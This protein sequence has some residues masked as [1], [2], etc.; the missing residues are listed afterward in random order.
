[1]ALTLCK[2]EAEMKRDKVVYLDDYRKAKKASSSN[3]MT[4]IEGHLAE[5]GFWED[6]PDE[7]W[8]YLDGNF[9]LPQDYLKIV[10]GR[11]NNGELPTEQE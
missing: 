5:A 9:K 3:L 1:M 7:L 8:R 2:V 11:N 10:P 6:E 4:V